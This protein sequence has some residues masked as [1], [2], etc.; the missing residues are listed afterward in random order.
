MGRVQE[1]LDTFYER[2]G[3]QNTDQAAAMNQKEK[4]DQ[5]NPK[6]DP[7]NDPIQKKHDNPK[8]A[9][10]AKAV[11]KSRCSQSCPLHWATMAN[12]SQSTLHKYLE[13][14]QWLIDSGC[15]THM[16]PFANDLTTDVSRSKSLV[17]VTN[18]NIMKGPKKG[19]A[20]I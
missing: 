11:I 19:T 4:D 5:P 12:S 1:I 7:N 3:W 15:S 16:T 13:L 9:H 2:Y 14:S 10:N 8:A 17:E 20:L 18:G 6:T